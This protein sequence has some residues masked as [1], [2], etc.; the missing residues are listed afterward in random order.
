M[1]RLHPRR[2][3]TLLELLVAVTITLL[4]AGVMLMVTTGTLDV[5]RRTQDDFVGGAQARLALDLLER[6]LQAGIFRKDGVNTW[7]AAD[8]I[9]SPAS[10]SDHG[11]R[12]ASQRLKPATSDSLRLVPDASDGLAP[13]LAEARF[14]LSGTWLRFI[15]TNVESGGSLPV[16]V[17]YQVVRRPVSGSNVAPDNPADVRYALFRS[18]VTP[19]VAF[20]GGYD[21]TAPVYGSGS[22]AA[23]AT[24]SA[25]TLTNPNTGDALASNVVDFGVWLHVRE[26]AGTL[27]RIFPANSTDLSHAARDGG[28]APDASRY[29]DVADI[30]VRILTEEGARRI[31]AME[32]GNAAMTRPAAYATDAAWWWAVVEANSR[33]FVRRVE[34]K[35]GDL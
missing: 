2:G 15:T 7:L 27:R 8:V 18:V 11:W 29:P 30:M 14:G 3:F 1:N 22:A 16:A 10:L 35:G 24:R 32:Q 12:T 6:D 4:L 23:P 31:E 34:I 20:T 25:A 21:V 33:V 19:E 5:W 9:N 28:A 26:A 17:S 13:N